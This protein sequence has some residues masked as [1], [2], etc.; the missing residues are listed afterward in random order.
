MSTTLPLATHV[1]YLRRLADS[2]LILGQQLSALVGWAPT[3]EEEVASANIALDLFGQASGLYERS[4][5]LIG[6]GCS[7]DDEAYTRS[8]RDFRNALLVE[9]LNGDFALNMVRQLLYEA[10]ALP[11]WADLSAVSSDATIRGVAGKAAKETQYHLRHVGMWVI[12]LGDGTE[13]SHA[14]AQLAIDALW[15]YAGELLVDDDVDRDAAHAGVGVLNASVAQ[16]WDESIDDVFQKAGLVRPQDVVAQ[17][18][19]RTGMHTER[20]GF[21]LAEMQH[22]RGAHVGAQW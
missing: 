20:L 10:W 21:I 7:A 3:L 12:R 4:A 19:G 17:I 2:P 14:R 16:S 22:L 13:E 5:E 18:G 1:D 8:D 9:R 15:P 11:M 6:S